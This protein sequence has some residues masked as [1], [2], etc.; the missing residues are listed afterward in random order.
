[1]ICA[2]RELRLL[3]L[4]H[5]FSVLQDFILTFSLCGCAIGGY[6]RDGYGGGGGYSGGGYDRY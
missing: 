5:F 2:P 4:L 6:D 1:M 3:L